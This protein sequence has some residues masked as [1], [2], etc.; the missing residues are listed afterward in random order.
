MSNLKVVVGEDLV[1]LD[2]DQ[3]VCPKC[4]KELVNKDYKV[5]RMHAYLWFIT[6]VISIILGSLI[7]GWRC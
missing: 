3:F 5:N 7:M 4:D 6:I 1:L 2:K